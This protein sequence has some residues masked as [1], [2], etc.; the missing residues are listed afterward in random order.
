MIVTYGQ[1]GGA[2][3]AQQLRQVAEGLN[4]RIAE[5]MPAL[6]LTRDQIEANDGS[7]TPERDLPRT[8]FRFRRPSPN[9]ARRLTLVRLIAP[10]LHTELVADQSGGCSTIHTAG[11][12]R[13]AA[14]T[15][16]RDGYG[17]LLRWNNQRSRGITMRRAIFGTGLALIVSAL[18]P[19]S[20]G[21][22][23][24][25]QAAH[26]QASPASAYPHTSWGAPDL[27]GFWS[28]ASITHMTRPDSLTTLVITAEQAKKLEA[29]DF[30]NQRLAADQKPT[31]QTLGAPVTGGLQAN[32]NYNAFWWDPGSKVA[33][34]NGEYRSSWIIEPANGRIP[35]KN[36]PAPAGGVADAPAAA[37]AAAKLA[38]PVKPAPPAASAPAASA[39]ARL[40]TSK[41]VAVAGP[42]TAPLKPEAKAFV[43]PGPSYGAVGVGR[44]ESAKAYEG[45]ESRSLGERCL[46]GFGGTG[47][48]VMNN[49]LYNNAYQIVQSP[50]SVMILVEMNHDARIIPILADAAT[51]AAAHKP[52]VIKPWLGD[53][54]G[55]YEGD[56]LVI[57]TQ[58]VN[59]FQKSYVSGG[60]RLI[61]RFSRQADGALLYRFEVDDPRQFTQTWK[62]EMP[63][64]P[65]KGGLYEYGCHEG[66]YALVGILQGAREKEKRGE[67]M[68][69]TAESE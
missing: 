21:Q 66:N 46:I 5:T 35:Y 3:C 43:E 47:G 11:F 31:D 42:V 17:D 58:D 20:H 4:M 44:I 39:P 37:G 41:P 50:Q 7:V 56:T 64:H 60:G 18:A 10:Q 27:Q 62:G 29:G 51:A 59:P 67:L 32:G 30:N 53:S 26:G 2:K 45:P 13:F 68:E 28:N 33:Q 15:C 69:A 57:E 38:A 8:A 49:V 6:K 52:N 36:R 25:G 12:C 34:V 61:E 22:A 9:L 48:P 19:A 55:W 16:Q 40:E 63:F 65:L 24:H 23:A 14:G 1:R 54:V